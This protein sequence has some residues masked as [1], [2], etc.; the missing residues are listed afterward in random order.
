MKSVDLLV[1]SCDQYEDCWE[2]FYKLKNKYWDCP[3]ETY[4]VTETKQYGNTININNPSWTYRFREALKQLTSDYVIV[5]LDDF[6]IR[7]KVD[8][9][10]IEYCI[11]QMNDDIAVFNFEKKY[12]NCENSALTGFERQFNNQV[13]L[14]SAQPSLWNKKALLSRLQN[15]QNPWEWETEVVRDKYIYYINTGDFIIDIGYRHQPLN[16]GFGITRG[17][18]TEECKIFLKSEGLFYEQKCK[19]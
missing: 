7:D 6:F 16:E 1:L 4:L 2:L 11:S 15:N 10:R 9:E 3:Y 14:Q 13:Y 5:M 12:R 19:A 17:K 18:I 8:Q